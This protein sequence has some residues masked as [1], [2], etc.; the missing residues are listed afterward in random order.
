MQGA[1][2]GADRLAT[3]R[4][5]GRRRRELHTRFDTVSRIEPNVF[6]SDFSGLMPII[7]PSVRIIEPNS[8]LRVMDSPSTTTPPSVSE[9]RQ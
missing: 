3:G 4:Q 2:G 6:F 8:P 5:S 1:S 7:E 9:K